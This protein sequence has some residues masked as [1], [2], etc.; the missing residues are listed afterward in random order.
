MTNPLRRERKYKVFWGVFL[1]ISAM[2]AFD[3]MDAAL[4]VDLVKYT[5]LGYM[6]ANVGEHFTARK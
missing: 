5:F 4:Y 3:K 2:L 6:T 1:V